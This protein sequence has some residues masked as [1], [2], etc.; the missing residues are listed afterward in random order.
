MHRLGGHVPVA[1]L[2]WQ[3]RFAAGGSPNSSSIS[4]CP[5][6]AILP[7][8][9][10]VSV[11]VLEASD[12]V[13]GRST[14]LGSL[15][16]P[17]DVAPLVLM[18]GDLSAQGSAAAPELQQAVH[19]VQALAVQTGV[20]LAQEPQIM[21]M[22]ELPG[23]SPDALDAAERCVVWPGGGACFVDFDGSVVTPQQPSLHAMVQAGVLASYAL[24]VQ[25]G[26]ARIDPI[27][28]C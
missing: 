1:G 13:G 27:H 12:Q 5:T 15:G 25:P 20:E 24:L 7:Q 6:L 22:P 11:T 9:C 17:L 14:R 21:L 26:P 19:M 4:L 3:G 2:A 23:V 18:P 10:G 28:A 8:R 16:T